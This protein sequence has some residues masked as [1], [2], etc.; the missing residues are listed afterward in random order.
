MMK[1]SMGSTS[2]TERGR[3]LMCPSLPVRVLVNSDVNSL[4]HYSDGPVVSTQTDI[5]GT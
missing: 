1:P 3:V 2:V 5:M 4:K